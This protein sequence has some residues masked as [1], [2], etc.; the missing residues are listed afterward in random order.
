MLGTNN[1]TINGHMSIEKFKKLQKKFYSYPAFLEKL[2]E[3]AKDM[4]LKETE[5]IEAGMVFL[6]DCPPEFQERMYKYYRHRCAE[7]L[8]SD[9][10]SDNVEKLISAFPSLTKKNKNQTK[11]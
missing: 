5:V 8:D 10:D 1:S 7:I 3:I 4:G 2:S 6:L 9:H 11:S